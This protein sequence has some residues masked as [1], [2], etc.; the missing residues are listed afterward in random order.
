MEAPA[1]RMLGDMSAS[2]PQRLV[3]PVRPVLAMHRREELD[4]RRPIQWV[5]DSMPVVPAHLPAPPK[6]EWL[7]VVKY[8][9]GG[10]RD[11]IW[12]VAD[13]LRSDLALVHYSRRP[14]LY[15]W[16][17]GLQELI[18]GVRP[19]QMDWHAIERPDWYLGE[20][21]AITP[22]TA[23]IAKE[24]GRG[25][26]YAPISGWIRRWQQPVNLMIGGRNLTPAGAPARVRVYV[27]GRSV[28]DTTAAPGFFLRMLALP[29]AIGDGDYATIT[30]DS[31]NRDLAI[32]QFDAQP[33]GRVVFGFGEGWHEQEYDPSTGALW[34]WSSERA[35]IRVRPEGHAVALS[36]RGEIEAASQSH[37]TIRAGDRI[38]SEFDV[39]RS[40]V[41][42]TIIPAEMLRSAETTLTIE[43]SASYVPAESR[44]RSR[45]RRRL[46]LK[47]YECLV[48]PVS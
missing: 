21:W 22:E 29:A 37:I 14:A 31:D 13:P 19:N 41:R 27:D 15:R 24:D 9:N 1:F 34:R 2:G 28:D 44:W 39:G 12:F 36:I 43:S 30:V 38:A 8:W 48:T 23:G 20:G 5:G 3:P 42:T 18:G 35:V 7:E 40:F 26:G 33:G 11:P 16:P 45:D 32:E 17:S 46:G 10:G 4:M 25:A 47:L 6:H